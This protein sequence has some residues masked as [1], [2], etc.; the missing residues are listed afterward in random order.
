MVIIPFTRKREITVLKEPILNK[1]IQL[2]SEFK[3]LGITLD[4]GLTCKTQLD[5]A[6]NKA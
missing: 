1:T 4:K 2:S 5:K 6:I 3:F